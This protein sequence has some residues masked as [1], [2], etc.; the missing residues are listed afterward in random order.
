MT[1][2]DETLIVV[3]ADHSHAYHVVGYATRNQSVLGVDDTD[4]G[5][6]KMPYLISNYANGPG[7]QINKSRPNP[8]NAGNLFEKSY[9][10]QSLV[11]LD[12]STH[13][14]DDVPLY[15]TGPYSQL[16]RR[17]TDNTYLTYAT[18]FALCLGQYEKETHC[19]SGFTLMTGT[20]SYLFPIISILFTYFVQKH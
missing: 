20:G 1:K 7:A 12:F 10:Q 18:M 8:L 13:E 9:Q 5:A 11:P 19:N 16:F 14:A 2:S 3:T 6:D 15:A 4:Q 17:P